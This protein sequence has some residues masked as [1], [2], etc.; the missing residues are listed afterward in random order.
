MKDRM[1]SKQTRLSG[2]YSVEVL[3]GDRDK[4]GKCV[5]D[6]LPYKKD[7][8]EYCLGSLVESHAF[9]SEAKPQLRRILG[10]HEAYRKEMKPFEDL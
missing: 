6:L 4:S 1:L 2:S 10:N 3:T 7:V 9:Q 5:F 8:A